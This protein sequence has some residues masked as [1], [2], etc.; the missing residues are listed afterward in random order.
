MEKLTL[1]VLK[2]FLKEDDDVV[3]VAQDKD[4]GVYAYYN[5]PDI[6]K[7][8]NVW[9]DEENMEYP[10]TSEFLGNFAEFHGGWKNSKLTRDS[11]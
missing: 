7:E 1:K 3:A 6:D 8:N 2:V 9:S 5:E 10:R 4:L 11:I